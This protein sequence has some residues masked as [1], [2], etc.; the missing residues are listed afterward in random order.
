M[1]WF[2]GMDRNRNLF[3]LFLNSFETYLES[4]DHQLEIAFK[5]HYGILLV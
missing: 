5:G 1:I 4:I 3:D 2:S